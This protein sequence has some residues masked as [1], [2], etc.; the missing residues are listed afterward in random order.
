ML[1]LAGEIVLFLI[2]AALVGVVAG[3]LVCRLL[4]ARRRAEAAVRH[5]EE[6]E[7]LRAEVDALRV[8]LAACE[9]ARD[10]AGERE[11]SD[12]APSRL[13]AALDMSPEDAQ[14][15]VKRRFGGGSQGEDD[16]EE[17]HGIGPK[18]AGMLREMGIATF[19]Q[20]ASFTDD[21]IAVVSAALSAFPDRILR[22]DWMSS[23]RER[24]AAAYGEQI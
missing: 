23:A 20:V 11:S 5:G 3:V 1:H 12:A 24:H 19:R 6:V 4:G 9:Q 2:A 8:R 22:D 7:A 10:E 15:E 13:I 21:D 18:I 14:A 16:L 17:I